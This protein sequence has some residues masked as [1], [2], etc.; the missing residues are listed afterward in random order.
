MSHHSLYRL[1]TGELTGSQANASPEILALNTPAGCAWV[2]GA[3]DPRRGI[4]QLVTDDNGEQVPVVVPRLPPRPA[5]SDYRTWAWDDTLQDWAATPTL[6]WHQAQA[7]EPVLAQLSAL[8]TQVARPVGEI[9]EAQALGQP[10]PAGALQRL[11]SINA[12]K[13]ALR[14]HLAAIA[15]AADLAALQAVLAAPP[16]LTS[17]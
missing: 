11:T 17:L 15:A 6:L 9:A 5:D 7:R 10:V 4:V 14:A 13:A 2:A 16:T 3:H 12:D 8:D 1:D